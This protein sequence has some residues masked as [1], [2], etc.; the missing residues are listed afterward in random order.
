MAKHRK[1]TRKP[2]LNVKKI[3][4]ALGAKHITDPKEKEEFEKRYGW[5]RPH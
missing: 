5:P 3:A 1:R 2:K 4:K